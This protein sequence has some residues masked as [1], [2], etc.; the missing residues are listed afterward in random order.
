MK[1]KKKNNNKI[2]VQ[3][4]LPLRKPAARK[5]RLVSIMMVESSSE[6]KEDIP[7]S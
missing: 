2:E 4:S 7:T 6:R 1:E 3:H 5:H